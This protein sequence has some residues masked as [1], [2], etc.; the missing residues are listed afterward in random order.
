MKEIYKGIYIFDNFFDSDEC[1]KYIELIENKINGPEKI[2]AFSDT[3]GAST[4]K[5]VDL[6]LATVFY[7]KVVKDLTK[8]QKEKMAIIRPN[9]LI[10]WSKYDPD[11]MFGLHTDTGLFYDKSAKE[12]TNY[13]LLAYLNDDFNG[14]ETVF[15]ND[16][17]KE[18]VRITPKAGTCV[19]FDINLWHQ[20]L[21]VLDGQKHWIGCELIGPC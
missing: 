14:G 6:K 13:T 9:N 11:A 18:I 15:Y 16:N 12:K 10:M 21:K 17:F 4:D 19:V 3:S 5:Y 2:I 7:D 1:K 20:G 8:I